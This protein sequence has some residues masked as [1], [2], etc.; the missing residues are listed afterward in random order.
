M[1]LDDHKHHHNQHKNNRK[2]SNKKDI[3][4]SAWRTANENWDNKIISILHWT[5]EQC[6][7]VLDSEVGIGLNWLE[8]D[9]KLELTW[10]GF[11]TWIWSTRHYGLG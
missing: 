2:L 8:I 6:E 11:W 1:T 5:E 7:A 3:S 10:I 9:L 4:L